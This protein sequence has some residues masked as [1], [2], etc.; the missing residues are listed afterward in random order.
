MIA[1]DEV[2]GEDPSGALRSRRDGIAQHLDVSRWKPQRRM[3]QQQ[4]CTRGEMR[5]EWG[6]VNAT[7]ARRRSSLTLVFTNEGE[8]ARRNSFT[9][10]GSGV[11]IIADRSAPVELCAAHFYERINW[12]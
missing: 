1:R 5:G 7:F 6:R 11:K 3:V 10:A 9:R 4:C 12:R 8:L 2:R